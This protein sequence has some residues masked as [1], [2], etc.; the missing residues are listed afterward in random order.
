ML[1]V[2][3]VNK[4]AELDSLRTA[5]QGLLRQTPEH[6]F[7]HTLEWL[8]TTWPH[9]PLSQKL[10]VMLIER[11]GAPLGIVPLCVRTERRK[12][13][14]VRVLTYPLNDW[15]TFYGPIGANPATAYHAAIERIAA[16]PRDW[17]FIDLRWI[18]QASPEF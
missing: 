13:G 4:L 14:L 9:Y 8:E 17:D 2:T 12:V 10:R 5:W 11:G 18:D 15:G 3:E 7:F 16:T 6:S 1:T